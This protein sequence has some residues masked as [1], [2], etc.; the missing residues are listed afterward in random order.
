MVF[1]FFLME[2]ELFCI[3]LCRMGLFYDGLRGG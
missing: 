1:G 3:D 2:K